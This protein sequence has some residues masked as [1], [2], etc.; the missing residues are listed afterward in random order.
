MRRGT[1][2]SSVWEAAAS[3]RKASELPATQ[4]FSQKMMALA[5]GAP[6]FSNLD[7]AEDRT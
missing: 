2:A 7:V 5:D 1:Y 6:T 4:E 3:D